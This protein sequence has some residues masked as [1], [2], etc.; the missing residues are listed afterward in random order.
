MKQKTA[1]KFEKW[2]RDIGATR[3]D[4]FI[5][6]ENDFPSYHILDEECNFQGKYDEGFF[7]LKLLSVNSLNFFFFI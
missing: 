3:K 6:N 4:D 7:I 1:E 2:C 5:D